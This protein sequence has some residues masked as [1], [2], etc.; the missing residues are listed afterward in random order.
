MISG[1]TF[2]LEI[3]S[4]D[5]QMDRPRNFI[6]RQ[7]DGQTDYYK[8]P[9]ERGPNKEDEDNYLSALHFEHDFSLQILTYIH[10][11]I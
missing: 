2:D 9:A 11:G 10:Q 1:M 3:S 4:T 5:R 6:H 7:T 8:S